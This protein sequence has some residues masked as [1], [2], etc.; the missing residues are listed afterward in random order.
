MKTRPR[1]KSQYKQAVKVYKC[2]MCIFVIRHKKKAQKIRADQIVL[3][4]QI[5]LNFST[6]PGST[7]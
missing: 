5:S 1:F 4:K 2:T 6:A 3:F 7:R